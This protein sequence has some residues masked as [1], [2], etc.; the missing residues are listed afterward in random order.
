MTKTNFLVV[1]I[2]VFILLGII[3]P[4]VMEDSTNPTLFFWVFEGLA[5]VGLYASIHS[6][7]ISYKEDKDLENDLYEHND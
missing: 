6:F 3:T 7:I 1:L 5:L 2:I 4:I